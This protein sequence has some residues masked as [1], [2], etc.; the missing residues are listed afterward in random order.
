MER[1]LVL[2]G[3]RA[4]IQAFSGLVAGGLVAIGLVFLSIAIWVAL[5]EAIGT[6]A[7]AALIGAVFVGAGLI[8]LKRGDSKHKHTPP[9]PLEPQ[10]GAR[11]VT[12][13]DLVEAFTIGMRAGK[14]PNRKL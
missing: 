7:A 10:P 8:V 11:D 9:P 1:R 2:A 4:G 5:E 6:V 12:V 14:G 3:R 13:S